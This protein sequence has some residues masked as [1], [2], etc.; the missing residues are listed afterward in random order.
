[1]KTLPDLK[2]EPFGGAWSIYDNQLLNFIKSRFVNPFYDPNINDFLKKYKTWA[3]KDHNIEGI[4]KFTNLCYANGTTEV[5]DK[6]YQKYAHKRLRLL[7]GEYYY[8]RIQAREIF[9]SFA[10]VEDEPILPN[11]VVV[12]SAPFSD[13]GNIPENYD[14]IMNR[15]SQYEIPVMLDMAYLNLTKNLSLN[16][17]YPC[18]E[19]IATSLSK[20]FP[21]ERFRIG[22][23]LMRTS[24]DDT[25]YAY[26]HNSVPYV[27][28][29]SINIA[30][31]LI[32]TFQNDW[33][34][35]KY[36][37]KQLEACKKLG[38]TPSS[39]VIF[40]IDTDQK[41]PQY[42]RGSSTN[43]LCFSRLWD[44]RFCRN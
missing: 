28:T 29:I 24:S 1:M 36:K 20:V 26:S 27:N 30:D 2:N 10:W 33:V 5:F 31:Y 34:F 7:K 11:D 43:R 32:T 19:V 15:C 18:I 12:L 22:M 42:N 14:E 13:T 39:C 6:F 44:E 17:T 23:R 8:H 41:Y 37:N 9:E 21:V 4:N 38:L 40:G 16:I 25:L 35:N 3:F